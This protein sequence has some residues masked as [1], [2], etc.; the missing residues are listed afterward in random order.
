MAPTM[1]DDSAATS[2]HEA[3]NAAATTAVTVE[4]AAAN[5]GVSIT[6]V[7]RRIRSGTLRAEQAQRPQGT[8]W[9]VY[10][11]AAATPAAISGQRGCNRTDHPGRSG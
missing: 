6:T 1:N 11:D 4:Q 5:L 7:K 2:G 9:L 10:L 3:P 8:V